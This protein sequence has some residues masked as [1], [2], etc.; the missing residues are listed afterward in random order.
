MQQSDHGPICANCQHVLTRT[1]PVPQSFVPNLIH[2]NRIPSPLEAFLIMES[3]S[4][5][6]LPQLDNDIAH[7]QFVLNELL[8]NRKELD[9]YCRDHKPLLSLI[10]QFPPE[11]LSHIFLLSLPTLGADS[12]MPFRRAILLPGQV[13]KYWR[14]VALS[15]PKL[16]SENNIILGKEWR[17][18]TALAQS[19]LTRS[20]GSPLSIKFSVFDYLTPSDSIFHDLL[21]Q[22]DRWQHIDI[23]IPFLL[24]DAFRVVRRRLASL[25][26]LSLECAPLPHQPLTPTDL[27]DSFETAPQLRSLTVGYRLSLAGLRVPWSQLTRCNI[28]SH[29]LT[30]DRFF[31]VLRHSPNL[32]EC[33]LDFFSR[34]A[35][36]Q[37]YHWVIRHDH[38]R[39]LSIKTSRKLQLLF[40]NLSLPALSAFSYYRIRPWG[41]Q[42]ILTSF[43]SLLS[44]SACSLSSLRLACVFNELENCL[45]LSPSLSEMELRSSCARTSLIESLLDQLTRKS[46]EN[47]HEECLLPNLRVVQ[48]RHPL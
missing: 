44:R 11:L 43:A 33:C 2:T 28:K 42:A 46:S 34:S 7:V 40:E 27:L 37:A 25:R 35:L 10:R 16:W 45:R 22:S 19:W 1:V 20:G 17:A 32:V 38:L 26:T 36:D 39:V 30:I 31:D 15:T 6:D 18:E 41:S 29:D 24:F 47:G 3:L 21:A 9:E 12:V 13:C 23:Y 5:I 8:R 14:D 4:T 48:A